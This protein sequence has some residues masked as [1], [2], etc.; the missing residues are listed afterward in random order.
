[1]RETISLGW[2]GMW[3]GL[4]GIRANMWARR[5]HHPPP[6]PEGWDSTKVL[7]FPCVLDT[8]LGSL[9][10]QGNPTKYY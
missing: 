5:P 2:L 1:M 9:H 7:R 10:L 3:A 6:V 8:E 4:A